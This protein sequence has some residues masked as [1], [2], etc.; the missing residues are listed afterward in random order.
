M[1]DQIMPPITVIGS[2]DEH[3]DPFPLFR[4][5]PNMGP[6]PPGQFSHDSYCTVHQS[7]APDIIPKDLSL[8]FLRDTAIHI[9]NKII[10]TPGSQNHEIGTF[11]IKMAN[12]SLRTSELV[13]GELHNVNFASG[14]LNAGEVIVAM[15]HSHTP[16]A[17]VE[18]GIPSSSGN[19]AGGGPGDT[20]VAR[21]LLNSSAVDP[22]MLNYIVDIASGNTY[23]YT[24]A[25][26]DVRPLGANITKDTVPGRCPR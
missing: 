10:H 22:G 18:T 16:I 12:G 15:I 24:A 6:P 9:A 8:E 14:P 26:P 13:K 17:G 25:G 1:S 2:N 20:V 5:F 11:I 4:P 3:Y 19:H 23:E 7:L 21:N